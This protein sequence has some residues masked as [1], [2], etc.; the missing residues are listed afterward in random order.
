MDQTQLELNLTSKSDSDDVVI[1]HLIPAQVID[2]Q[3]A[4]DRKQIQKMSK[5]YES[6]LESVEHIVH[7]DQ[8]FK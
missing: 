3:V 6:I 2:L 7:P 5:V 4:R 8:R 1:A